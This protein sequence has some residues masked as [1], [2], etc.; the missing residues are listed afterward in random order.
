MFNLII[1]VA[2]A[3]FAR[4]AFDEGRDSLGWLNLLLSAANAALFMTTV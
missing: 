1:A 2:C 3:Y 4:L